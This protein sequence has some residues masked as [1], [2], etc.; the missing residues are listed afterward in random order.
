V[1]GVITGSNNMGVL[2]SLARQ[3]VSKD[4]DESSVDVAWVSRWMLQGKWHSRFVE[5]LVQSFICT[6]FDVEHG[7]LVD[8]YVLCYV[9]GAKKL[10]VRSPHKT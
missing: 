1:P 5:A 4:S 8:I 7:H 6:K 10:D 3:N 2:P 9:T